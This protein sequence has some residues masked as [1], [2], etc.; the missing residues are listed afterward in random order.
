M[1]IPHRILK[2]PPVTSQ[3]TKEAEIRYDLPTRL[4]ASRTVKDVLKL[5][6]PAVPQKTPTMA[7]VAASK[8][9]NSSKPEEWTNVSRKQYKNHGAHNSFPNPIKSVEEPKRRII[10]T[11]QKGISST[12]ATVCQCQ[13][14]DWST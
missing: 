14:R 4:P 11:R 9:L 5:T 10:F 8:I 1:A 6:Q 3:Q 7:Q 2:I 13:D 12:P